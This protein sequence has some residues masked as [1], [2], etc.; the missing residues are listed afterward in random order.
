MMEEARKRCAGTPFSQPSAKRPASAATDRAS[1]VSD[2]S[3]S[4]YDNEDSSRTSPEPSFV[5]DTEPPELVELVESA[6]FLLQEQARELRAA[7]PLLEEL[8][9]VLHGAHASAIAL[10]SA[11][12]RGH[13]WLNR[14]SLQRHSEN[15]VQPSLLASVPPPAITYVPALPRHLGKSGVLS[16]LQIEAM[17]YAGQRHRAAVRRSVGPSCR[18]GFLLADGAGVGKGRTQAAIILD[19]WLQGQQKA[20]WITASADLLA[21][22][23]RDLTAVCMSRPGLPKLHEQL[24]SLA[25]IPVHQPIPN[26]RGV[27]FATYLL[28]ARPARLAQVLA[29]CHARKTFDGT[30]QKTFEG[31][32]SFDECHK[33]KAGGNTGAGAAVMRLQ[34]DLPLAKVVYA[35]ATAATELHNMQYLTRLGLWGFG[36][37][38]PSFS[39]FRDELRAGGAAAQALLPLHLKLSGA[40]VSRVISWEGV[41]VTV[42]TH[43][44]STAQ[45]EA[46]DAAAR[47]WLE[48]AE[49]LLA[50]SHRSLLPPSAGS[51]FWSA[52][53]R[54]FRCLVT[55][56]KLPTL[57][58]LLDEGLARGKSVVIGLLSTGEAYGTEGG[59]NSTAGSLPPAPSAILKTVISAVLFPNAKTN[60]ADEAEAAAWLRRSEALVLP[61]NPLDDIMRSLA[62]RGVPTVGNH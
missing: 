8:N 31:V 44:L 51:R 33:A 62:D 40:L 16:E 23:K 35:S 28:L 6:E 26:A 56:S 45:R 39:A 15:A 41:R 12:S 22:A 20:L 19:V 43:R 27:L 7:I 10:H 36:T 4:P 59:A 21:D 25:S 5:A 2:C 34:A 18:P 37:P 50:R 1:P 53:Q 49:V 58:S 14:M 11:A 46:Y 38:F 17:L 13:T 30:R 47:L 29:W 48:L 24:I 42:A 55:A 54:F 61:A 52:H 3:A 32:I 9:T 57:H 60:S